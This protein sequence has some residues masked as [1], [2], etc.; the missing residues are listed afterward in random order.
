MFGAILKSVPSSLS[1][2]MMPFLVQ[3]KNTFCKSSLVVSK[4][5][6]ME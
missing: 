3:I 5:V 1:I 4:T 2:M 6:G